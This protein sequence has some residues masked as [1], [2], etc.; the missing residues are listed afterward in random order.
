MITEKLRHTPL[1]DLLKMY[2]DCTIRALDCDKC[3]L[4]NVGTETEDCLAELKYEI[5]MRLM[6]ITE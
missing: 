5:G 6:E 2:D 1:L 3:P 4:S